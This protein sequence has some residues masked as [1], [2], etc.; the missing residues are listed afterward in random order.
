MT[1][2][3]TKIIGNYTDN[4]GDALNDLDLPASKRGINANGRLM[5]QTLDNLRN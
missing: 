2:K 1:V 4:L 5:N 3:N